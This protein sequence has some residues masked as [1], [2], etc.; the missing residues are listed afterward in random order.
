MASESQKNTLPIA[1]VFTN[2]FHNFPRLVLTNLL[3]A[4]PLS[5]FTALLTAAMIS[6]SKSENAELR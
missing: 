4:V 6:D 2:L 5:A 1:A 3:F